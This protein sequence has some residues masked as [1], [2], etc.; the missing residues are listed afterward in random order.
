MESHLSAIAAKLDALTAQ[1]E[2]TVTYTQTVASYHGNNNYA[3]PAID[4]QDLVQRIAEVKNTLDRCGPSIGDNELPLLDK[5]NGQIDFLASFTVPHLPS[6]PVQAIPP[7]MFTLDAIQGHI[8]QLAPRADQDAVISSVNLQKRRVRAVDAKLVEYEAQLADLGGTVDVIRQ[9]HEAATNLPADLADLESARAK[10]D[11]AIK[12]IKE[13]DTEIFMAKISSREAKKELEIIEKQ[14]KEILEK[15]DRALSS[16]T[17]VGLSIAFQ[18]RSRALAWSMWAWS[19]GLVAALMF[20]FFKGSGRLQS[21]SYLLDEPVIDPVRLI[22]NLILAVLSIGA[23][24]WLAWIATKQIGQRFRL[25]E[26]YAFKASIS[27]AYEGYRREASRLDKELSEAGF[28]TEIPMEARLLQSALTR[29][30][31]LPLR[32]VESHTHGSP[33]AELFTSPTV[34]E[35]TKT[36]PGFVDQIKEAARNAINKVNVS[37]RQTPSV[38]PPKTADAE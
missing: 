29:L 8:E 23:P 15:C 28:E 11:K 7:F 30:D 35:A 26:D 22:I 37:K 32:L 31:E 33:W 24:I 25:S 14:A 18:K 9:A 3:I 13:A 16:S 17:S 19:A 12:E 4:K 34:Q 27:Q 21:V 38:S 6:H 36:V 10:I 20:G 2:S 5:I 1:V